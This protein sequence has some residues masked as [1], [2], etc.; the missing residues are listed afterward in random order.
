MTLPPK[1]IRPSKVEH[2]IRK[3]AKR[4]TLGYNLITAEMATRLPKKT[5]LFLTYIYNSMI[6]LSHFL[7]LWKFSEIIMVLKPGNP[8]TSLNH[9]GPSVFFP[10]FPR[11]LKNLF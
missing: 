8:R 6:R 7:I 11:F 4:K 10:Y 1:H 9:I 3:S 2:A 5:L